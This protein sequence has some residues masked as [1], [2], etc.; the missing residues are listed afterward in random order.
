MNHPVRVQLSRAKGWRMPANTVKVDRSNRVFG[1]PYKVCDTGGRDP[2][3]RWEVFFCLNGGLA[4]PAVSWWPSKRR[5]QEAAV[6][7]FAARITGPHGD[8]L[9]SKLGEL[10]GK[11]LACWCAPPAPGKPDHCHAAV[12]LEIANAIPANPRPLATQQTEV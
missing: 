4:G 6:M 9:R 8:L 12:L 11:N 2:K 5:A 1:N 7:H 10:R 3:C